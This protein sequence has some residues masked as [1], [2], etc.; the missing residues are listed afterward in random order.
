MRFTPSILYHGLQLTW[1]TADYV[2]A[3]TDNMSLKQSF[4]IALYFVVLQC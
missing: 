2:G 4:Y 3:V 1:H